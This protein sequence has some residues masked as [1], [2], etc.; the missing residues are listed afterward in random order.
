MANVRSEP[1]PVQFLILRRFPFL[2]VNGSSR[3]PG[4]THG[5]VLDDR[6]VEDAIEAYRKELAALTS[7]ELNA[8]YAEER[9]K[10]A[11]ELRVRRERE[12]QAL[13]FHQPSAN[14]DFSHWS[15]AAHWTLDESIALS[16]GKAPERVTWEHVRPLVA[17]SPFASQYARRRDLAL[18]AV[19]WKQLF[20]PVLPGIFLAWCKRLDLSVPAELTEAVQALGVQIADW[21]SRYEEMK[22]LVEKVGNDWMEQAAKQGED[23]ARIVGERNEQ[24][25]TLSDRIAELEKAQAL[26]SASDKP[27]GVRERESLLKLV[28][29]MAV[30]GY[31]YDARI[32]RSPH[33]AEIASDLENAGVS[34]DVD[35]VRKW[36]RA[37]AELLPPK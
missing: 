13:F 28:I 10:V 18:R 6:D 31:R 34:L 19:P 35:T 9:A 2:G 16:F 1:N 33:V 26:A 27:L 11:E 24:I 3:T 12:E 17:V 29:G 23:W 14:A 37:A 21:Q 36:L 15:K 22:A 20:D 30:E 25:A 7:D 8:R 4:G 5:P 32:E